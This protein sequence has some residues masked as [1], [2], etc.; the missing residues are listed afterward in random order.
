MLSMPRSSWRLVPPSPLKIHFSPG[1]KL[2]HNLRKGLT[3]VTQFVFHPN[4][5][6]L[7]ES[8]GNDLVRFE[9]AQ[10]QCE[11]LGR[12]VWQRGAQFGESLR[13]I[14]K[15]EKN[16][17]LPPPTDDVQRCA[18]RTVVPQLVNALT[19]LCRSGHGRNFRQFLR[20]ADAERISLP[21]PQMEMSHLPTGDVLRNDFSAAGTYWKPHGVLPLAKRAIHNWDWPLSAESV[22]SAL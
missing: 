11:C 6:F 16:Q 5:D 18:H 7:I 14:V 9:L 8:P 1:F 19:V 22:I 13:P 21:V 10:L 20:I 4:R 3:V 2:F 15:I 17:R 12:H